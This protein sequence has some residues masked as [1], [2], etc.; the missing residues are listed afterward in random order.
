MHLYEKA[1]HHWVTLSFMLG[2]ICDNI[3]LHRIDAT[4]TNTIL[5]TYTLLTMLSNVAL[6]IGIAG[7]MGERINHFLREYST[8]VMQF[9]FGGV[10]SGMLIFY[11]RSGSLFDSWPFLLLIIGVIVGNETIKNRGHRLVYNLAIFYIGLQA[12][13]ELILPVA[14]GK[15]GTAVFLGGGAIALFIMYWFFMALTKVVPNFIELQ[16]RNVVFVIGII[17]MTFNILYFMNIIPPVPLALKEIGIYHNVERIG[18]NTYR[19][20]YEKRPWW[21]F[22]RSTDATYHYATGDPAY[23]FAAVFA[24]TRLLTDIYH[25]WEYYDA[26]KKQWV[27]YGRYAYSISGGRGEGFRGYTAVTNLHEGTWRCT[28]E[29]ARGQVLGR[30]TFT[31]VSGEHGELVTKEE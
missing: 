31:A 16:K 22:Y 23:C 26:G 12:Y 5:L 20:S 30:E 3:L 18:N 8:V 21:Q 6:Y 25:R 17:Y 9:C 15:M 13:S 24:P 19:L 2:F 4:R 10:L 1:K 29:T 28:V 7:R 14:L 27:L 11:S